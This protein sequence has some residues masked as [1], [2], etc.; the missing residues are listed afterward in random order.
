[1]AALFL[2]RQGTIQGLQGRGNALDSLP[3]DVILIPERSESMLSQAVA[4][5][6][7][8]KIVP[9][10]DIDLRLLRAL[11]RDQI[12]EAAIFPIVLKQRVVNLLYVDNGAYPI[13]LTTYS[14]LQT[15]V[16][17]ASS[18]YTDLIKKR[19]EAQTT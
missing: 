12:C 10:T 19:K 6:R 9:E 15:L 7:S 3:I 8:I 11:G 13:A 2:V 18:A 4:S 1:V 14:A 17:C 5:A 16:E